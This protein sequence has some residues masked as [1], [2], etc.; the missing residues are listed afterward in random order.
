M[1]PSLVASSVWKNKMLLTLAEDEH[2][3][4]FPVLTVGCIPLPE[5]SSQEG[6]TD[7]RGTW[8]QLGRPSLHESLI[9]F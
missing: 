2:N 5:M 8:V 7:C 1:S 9:H 4:A 3:V 6:L